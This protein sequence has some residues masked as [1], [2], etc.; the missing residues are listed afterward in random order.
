MKN[1]Q[2]LLITSLTFLSL[3]LDSSSQDLHSSCKTEQDCG[4]NQE[5]SIT[6]SKC[7][8]IDGFFTWHNQFCVDKLPPQRFGQDCL[9][10]ETCSIS[11]DP[12]LICTWV[13]N[14]DTGRCL[15]MPGYDWVAETDG[16]KKCTKAD[17]NFRVN[18]MK[19]TSDV[20][21]RT[22]SEDTR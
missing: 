1:L 3:V 22:I 15:C 20:E 6:D 14:A 19:P 8:C 7:V 10:N 2:I 9:V 5:C 11:G 16:F 12:N 18:K 17:F 13:K 21:A 4:E